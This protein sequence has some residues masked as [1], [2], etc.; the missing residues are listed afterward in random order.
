M[1]SGFLALVL[2]CVYCFALAGRASSDDFLRPLPPEYLKKVNLKARR[3]ENDWVKILQSFAFEQTPEEFFHKNSDDRTVIVHKQTAKAMGERENFRWLQVEIQFLRY[4]MATKK[5]PPEGRLGKY[6]DSDPKTSW[7][8]FWADILAPD[9]ESIVP[10][11]RCDHRTEVFATFYDQEGKE[12]NTHGELA[13]A[14]LVDPGLDRRKMEM[15]PGEK[16]YVWFSVPDKAVYWYE[17]VPK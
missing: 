1:R 5:A 2:A 12:L 8:L 10:M 6:Q 9:I 11:F 7:E 14:Y 3:Q 17:W 4:C 16:T 13:F 15:L